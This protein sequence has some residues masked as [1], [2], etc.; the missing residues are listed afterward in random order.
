MKLPMYIWSIYCGWFLMIWF[1]VSTG[2]ILGALSELSDLVE[3]IYRPLSYLM[4]PLSGCFY[5]VEWLP[6]KYRSWALYVPMVDAI[7]LI[8]RGYFGERV[9]TYANVTYVCYFCATEMF[10]GLL[11]VSYIKRRVK[12][13]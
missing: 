6:E 13:A 5:L 9:H 2:L 1:A 4:V 11:L 10:I 12:F 3:K 7:E 8:R